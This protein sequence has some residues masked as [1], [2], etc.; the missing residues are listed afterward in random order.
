ML[1]KMLDFRHIIQYVPI[2]VDLVLDFLMAK[3]ASM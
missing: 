1:F 2:K 3:R